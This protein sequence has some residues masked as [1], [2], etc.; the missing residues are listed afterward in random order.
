MT[1]QVAQA[2]TE[3]GVVVV[4]VGADGWT[5]LGE[6]ARQALRAAG[7]IIGSPR[8]LE[9][10]PT[11]LGAR[12]V[13]WRS[14]LR[15]GIRSLAEEYADQGLVVLASGDPLLHGIGRTL[16]EEL[17]IARLRF[18]PALSS[19]A[20]ACARLGWPREDIEVV[21]AVG[22]GLS[23]LPEAFFS[24]ARFLVLS[25]G[26]DTPCTV[27]AM[28]TEHGFADS[29][30]VVLGDLGSPREQRWEGTAAPGPQ[31]STPG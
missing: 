30:V 28:L 14:P 12:R 2:F 25:A 31:R 1:P 4:G 9:H 7:V 18:L 29:T 10:L 8:L 16:V 15:S 27:A 17:G 11:W 26:R 21:N 24:G 5:G 23:G 13:D 3:R 19:V 6:E 22:G 20:L